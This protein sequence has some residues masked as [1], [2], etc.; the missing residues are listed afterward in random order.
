MGPE[1]DRENLAIS[2]ILWW[3]LRQNDKDDYTDNDD[4]GQRV[5]GRPRPISTTPNRTQI[6]LLPDR[7]LLR[8]QL[9][10]NLL[11]KKFAV[12]FQRLSNLIYSYPILAHGKLKQNPRWIIAKFILKKPCLLCSFQ[13]NG[14]TTRSPSGWPPPRRSCAPRPRRSLSPN[15]TTS[16]RSLRW[17]TDNPV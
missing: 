7:R 12:W 6:Q 11:H 17:R 1:T 2:A 4:D 16:T 9:S 14:N 5:G 8:G 15:N 3:S 13:S 10:Y